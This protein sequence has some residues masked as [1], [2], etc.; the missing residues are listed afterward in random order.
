[1]NFDISVVGIGLAGEQRLDLPALRFGFQRL[2]KCDAFLL[3]RRVILGF[4]ELDQSQRVLELA[5]E[6]RQRP[7]PLLKLGALAHYFLR[8]LSIVPEVRV[9]GFGVQLGEAAR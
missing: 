1:M 9:F 2:Q 7:E 5:L 3:G 6:A 8:G 4:A